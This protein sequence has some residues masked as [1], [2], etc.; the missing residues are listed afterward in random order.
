MM[1]KTTIVHILA[2]L[3]P[4][5]HFDAPLSLLSSTAAL[6]EEGPSHS[7]GFHRGVNGT[8]LSLPGRLPTET[9]ASLILV[10]EHG[11]RIWREVIAYVSERL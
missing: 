2:Q 1:M 5:S 10:S 7:G 6:T 4:W 3:L 11:S 8:W 9:A